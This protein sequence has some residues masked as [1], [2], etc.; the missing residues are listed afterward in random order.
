VGTLLL[1]RRSWSVQDASRPRPRTVDDN[2]GAAIPSL[3]PRAYPPPLAAAPFPGPPG[4]PCFGGSVSGRRNEFHQSGFAS[5]GR[6][7]PCTPSVNAGQLNRRIFALVH[8]PHHHHRGHLT[9]LP[10]S[11]PNPTLNPNRMT[12]VTLITNYCYY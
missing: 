5:D 12:V 7:I 2:T 4:R 10:E 9:P 3:F 8:L 6:R 1:S 11:N